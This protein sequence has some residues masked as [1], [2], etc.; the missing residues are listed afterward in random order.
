MSAV[1]DTEN[2]FLCNTEN[3]CQEISAWH[4]ATIQIMGNEAP[5]ES[6]VEPHKP[7]GARHELYFFLPL[8]SLEPSKSQHPSLKGKAL[9][10]PARTWCKAPIQWPGTRSFPRPPHSST[11]LTRR[12]VFIPI[13]DSW[14]HSSG[15]QQPG[16]RSQLRATWDVDHHPTRGVSLGNGFLPISSP[17]KP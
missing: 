1:T 16:V 15:A 7:F 8:L 17:N 14:C 10:H 5:L 13:I 2:Q 9:L 11:M 4:T 3:S 6:L 12:A